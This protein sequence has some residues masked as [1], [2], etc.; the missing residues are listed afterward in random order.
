MGDLFIYSFI[1]SLIHSLTLECNDC[2]PS[3]YNL[4]LLIDQIATSKYVP[5]GLS[6]CN[7]YIPRSAGKIFYLTTAITLQ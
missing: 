6:E 2:V 5:A 3:N 4:E 1:H 7:D